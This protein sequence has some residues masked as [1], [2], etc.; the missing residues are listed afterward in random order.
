M[1]P[2]LNASYDLIL[3]NGS[4]YTMD[5]S[6]PQV[7]AL[8]LA[9]NRIAAVGQV[10]DLRPDLSPHGT[11]L[12]LEGSTIVP[13]LIDSH[14]HF[15]GYSLRLSQVDLQEVP[16]LEE[17]LG[18]VANQVALSKPGTWIFPPRMVTRPG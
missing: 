17:A 7:S 16:S 15:S 8:A 13:G 3:H 12:D 1:P 6:Q 2:A 4:I 10:Q 11:V 5:A 18:R 14:L 9:G